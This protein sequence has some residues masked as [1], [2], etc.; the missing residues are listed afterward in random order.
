MTAPSGLA[1]MVLLHLAHAARWGV[2]RVELLHE[3]RLDEA[4]LRD[5]DARV[6]RAAIVRLWHA[7]AARVPDPAFGL[8][9][10]ADARAREFGLVGY[11]LAFSPTVGAALSASP[12]T[13]AS[14]RTPLSSRSRR[15]TL[16]R[17]CAWTWNRRSVR[18]A[19]RRTFASRPCWRCAGKSPRP[20][21]PP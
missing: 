8:R 18:S 1:R 15:R 13:I 20:P 3:A 17:G 6:P 14:C 4:Q 16:A 5:P 7:V 2:S 9:L 21:S 11:T 19:R 10:G 12:A